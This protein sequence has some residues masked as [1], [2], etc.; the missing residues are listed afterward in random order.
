MAEQ[1]GQKRRDS[2]KGR[3]DGTEA[4]GKQEGQNRPDSRKGRAEGTELATGQQEGQNRKERIS[5]GT[6]GR[7]EQQ[8]AK[9]HKKEELRREPV[10]ATA[11]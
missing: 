7:A 4:T 1:T 5:D 10:L 3:T 6:A 2:R 8:K 11:P 9:N